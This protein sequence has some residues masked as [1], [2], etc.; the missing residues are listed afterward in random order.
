MS[1]LVKVINAMPE[2]LINF[3]AGTGGIA[4]GQFGQVD[5]NTVIDAVEG[6][7]T[8]IL[9]GVALED[10]DAGEIAILAPIPGSEFELDIYQGGATD[11]FTD[12]DIGKAFDIYVDGTDTYIDPNDTGGAFLVLMS[13]DNTNKKATCR[14]LSTVNYFA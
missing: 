10:A 6:C 9:V 5:T 12:A 1:H 13:Y 2:R 14:A 7:A 8:A 11:V 3:S 4:K